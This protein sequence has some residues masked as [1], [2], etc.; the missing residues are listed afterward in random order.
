MRHYANELNAGFLHKHSKNLS[1]DLKDYILRNFGFGEFVFRDPE[2]LVEYCVAANLR[3]LQ[4]LIMTVP[5]NILIYH[6]QRDD[7]SKWLNA[8]ALFPIAQIFKPA[9]LE[10]FKSRSMM[11]ENTFIKPYQVFAQAKPRE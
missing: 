5:D 6:T 11:S 2:T 7:I 4:Q 3:D 9:K 10:D 1:N 8:R